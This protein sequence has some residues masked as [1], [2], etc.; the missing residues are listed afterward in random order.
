[1]TSFGRSGVPKKSASLIEIIREPQFS[2]SRITSVDRA[3]AELQPVHQRLGAEGAALVAAAR[4]LHEGAVDV[5][6]LLEQVVA[7]HR[8]VYHR[9]QPVRPV[10]AAHLAAL[11]IVQDPVEHELRFADHHRVAVL[12]RLWGMK[13]G[14]TPPITTGTPRARNASAIS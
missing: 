7:R 3:V 8:Q 14:C 6:V 1:M 10:D 9:V 13:L 11:E 2:I 12:E 4:G 5:A